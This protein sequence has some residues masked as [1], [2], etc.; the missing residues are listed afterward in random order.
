[1]S[2]VTFVVPGWFCVALLAIVAVLTLLQTVRVAQL[3]REQKKERRE[4]P[5]SAVFDRSLRRYV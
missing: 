3:W 1:M 4:A 2:T 5:R